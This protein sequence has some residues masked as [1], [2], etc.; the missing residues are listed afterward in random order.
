MRLF[1]KRL[2]RRSLCDKANLTK[3]VVAYLST[4]T[5]LLMKRS[6]LILDEELASPNRKAWP[7]KVTSMLRLFVPKFVFDD[8]PYTSIV[9]MAASVLQAG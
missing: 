7:A 3:W 2:R 1:Q 5:K 4:A 6:K 8:A 9:K